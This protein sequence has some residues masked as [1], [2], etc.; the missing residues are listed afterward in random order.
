MQ[1]FARIRLCPFGLSWALARLVAL[2]LSLG[3]CHLSP[4]PRGFFP[5]GVF[6]GGLFP[7]GLFSVG[8]FPGACDLAPGTLMLDICRKLSQPS[9]GELR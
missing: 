2:A 8:L 6:P 1:G 7:G 4:V 9:H 3:A 5:G